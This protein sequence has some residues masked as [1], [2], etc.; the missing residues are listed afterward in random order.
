MNSVHNNKKRW[1][2]GFVMRGGGVVTVATRLTKP[3]H[4]FVPIKLWGTLLLLLTFAHSSCR[5]FLTYMLVTYCAA[6]PVGCSSCSL[7]VTVCCRDTEGIICFG[8]QWSRP[9]Q[10]RDRVGRWGLY[11][12]RHTC[13]NVAVQETECARM[14]TTT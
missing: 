1:G 11:V 2:S 12:V 6:H 5:S 4:P 3:S 10:M 8:V 13:G 7:V 14:Q 9:H